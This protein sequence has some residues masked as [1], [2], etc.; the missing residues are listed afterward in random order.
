MWILFGLNHYPED[1][2]LLSAVPEFRRQLLSLRDWRYVPRCSRSCRYYLEYSTRSVFLTAYRGCYRGSIVS[3]VDPLISM[4]HLG[5]GMAATEHMVAARQKKN[6]DAQHVA[7]LN[8]FRTCE[9]SS[10]DG[11]AGCMYS[12][13]GTVLGSS[14]ATSWPGCSGLVVLAAGWS[15]EYC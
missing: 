8:F 2:L 12:T 1:Y 9:A 13:A 7:L 14:C 6:P 4:L 3:L 5:A 15:H 10:L 11:Y